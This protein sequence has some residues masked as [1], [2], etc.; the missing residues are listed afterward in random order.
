[1]TT[2]GIEEEY[3]F[4]D[5]ATLRPASVADSIRRELL[6]GRSHSR[7]VAHEFLASQIERSTPVFDTIDQAAAD[8][9]TFRRRLHDLA[10]SH[11]VLA[12]SVGVPFDVVGRPEITVDERYQVVEVEFRGLVTDHLVNGTHVHV[13]IP[14]R[15][16][17]VQVLNRIRVWLPTL[18]ALAGNSPYWR[19]EDSGFVSWRA[20]HLRRWS[21]IGCP[22]LFRDADDYDDRVGRL[23][24]VGGTYDAQTIA[25]SARLSEANPTVEVRVSDAQLDLGATLLLAALIRGLVVTAIADA[26]ADAAPLDVD[27][28]LLDAA[29]WHAARDGISGLLLNPCTRRLEPATDV[30]ETM[31]ASITA[32]LA[33][34]GDL[35]RVGEQMARI[36]AEGTGATRQRAAVRAGGRE[37]LG[38]LFASALTR[39]SF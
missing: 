13:G 33:A 10:G 19:G 3:M 16:T 5:P 17:G 34:E 24:G 31:I 8:L 32:A 25:W 6:S 36:A 9:S 2:F 29:L 27:P 39:Q 20:V 30:V 18:L 11:G 12:A 38:R 1:M 4:L 21:T 35:D 7:F 26:R 14:D 28:E 23:L 37:A 22:P 15:S